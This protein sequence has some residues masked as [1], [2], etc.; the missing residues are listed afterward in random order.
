MEPPLPLARASSSPAR[1]LLIRAAGFAAVFTTL[2]LAWQSAR[3][4]ALERFVIHTCIVR[5]AAALVDLATPDVHAAAVHFSLRATGGGLDILNGCDGLGALF[6]LAGAFA[7]V[8][9][10][11]RLRLPGLLVGAAVVYVANQARIL[12]L[13]YA[14]RADHALFDTLHASVTPVALILLV[15][16][17]FYAWLVRSSRFLDLAS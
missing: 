3:G 7:V 1:P 5:P 8:P 13:F 15:V 4:T 12:A 10:P 9:M 14:Y 2:E 11:W 6:L 16:G 17:Y